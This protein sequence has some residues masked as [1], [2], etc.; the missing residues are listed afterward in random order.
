MRNLSVEDE[1]SL[2]RRLGNVKNEL[3]VFYMNQS[4]ALVQGI[5]SEEQSEVTVS[6]LCAA[7]DLL[8]NSRKFLQEGIELFESIQDSANIALLMSNSG[9]LW[10]IAG[11]IKSLTRGQ[12]R[13]EFGDSELGEYKKAISE[14]KSALQTLNNRKVNPGVWDSVT[15]E[16]CCTF[17]TV[18]TLLQDQAPLSSYSR[19]ETEKQVT[20][21]FLKSLKY[22]DVEMSGPRQV[23][24]QYRAAVIHQRLA[25]LYHHAFRCFE[26]QDN[27]FRKKKLK[28]LS[29]NHYTKAAPLFLQLERFGDYLRCVLEKCGLY[30]AVL[31]GQATAGSKHKVYNTIL[32]AFI[33]T[34]PALEKMVAV[35]M[36][37]K[38]L[39]DGGG[40]KS[41]E[42]K[43]E[44]GF[45]I[46]TLLQR[47]QATLLALYKTLSGKFAKKGKDTDSLTVKVK[48]LYGESLKIEHTVEQIISLMN[49]IST[50]LL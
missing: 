25:S 12:N 39:S 14:Y 10:R 34:T 32:A 9:R 24:Y 45:M 44:E 4:T 19:E 50:I 26:A 23:V 28:Q 6:T 21:Y 31:E 1:H 20:E 40:E 15:W 2:K 27:S 47:I 17:F 38:E 33:E 18:G 35:S 41:A 22:C 37:V 11:H 30:E 7:E 5:N 42:D 16:L 13:N 29:E 36:N 48:S 43:E 49:K 3:G 46:E 8:I